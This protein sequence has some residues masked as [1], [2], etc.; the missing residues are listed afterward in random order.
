MRFRMVIHQSCLLRYQECLCK[1]TKPAQLLL[2]ANL[3]D[4]CI[5]NSPE[6]AHRSLH[7]TRIL[8]DIEVSSFV[9]ASTIYHLWDTVHRKEKTPESSDMIFKLVQILPCNAVY[10]SYGWVRSA[11]DYRASPLTHSKF[12]YTY[13]DSRDKSS[14]TS[15][16]QST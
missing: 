8:T 1:R 13:I 11:K 3:C 14:L 4:T 12:I 7:T 15:N 16:I 9:D 10:T 2:R 6:Y 5:V